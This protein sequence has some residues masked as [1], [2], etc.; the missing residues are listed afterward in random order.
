MVLVTP[1]SMGYAISSSGEEES[2]SDNGMSGPLDVP[3]SG[4][5]PEYHME[6]M[7]TLRDDLN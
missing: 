1:M 4:E 5:D 6:I 3:S 7:N 2:D